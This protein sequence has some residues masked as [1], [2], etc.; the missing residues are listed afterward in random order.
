MAARDIGEQLARGAE[1]LGETSAAYG[2]QLYGNA[3]QQAQAQQAAT[4]G[5]LAG[6]AVGAEQYNLE[7]QNQLQRQQ[8]QNQ[9]L[10]AQTLGAGEAGQLAGLQQQYGL[11]GVTSDEQRARQA[12]EQ[13]Q[14]NQYSNI[15]TTLGGMGG[16]STSTEKT[17]PGLLS[18]IGTAMNVGQGI[19]GMFSDRRLKRN[20]RRIGTLLSYPL[21]VFDYI[22]GENNV[23][24]FMSDEV[25]Q[26]AVTVHPSGYDM[27]N[28][29]LVREI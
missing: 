26:D 5:Q 28:L 15:A 11:Q 13:N 4:G 9:L 24:G 12:F 20:I 7:R 22:W 19:M 17:D 14:L 8:L 6:Q 27:I 16:T 21:Y 10:G 25:N 3:Y 23:V 2:T 18:S 29:N 1:N